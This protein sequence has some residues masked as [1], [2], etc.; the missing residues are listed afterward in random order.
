VK[1]NALPLR[2][3]KAFILD[4]RPVDI[5]RYFPSIL[6][7]SDETVIHHYQIEDFGMPIR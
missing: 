3:D 7:D 4:F 5:I 6:A 1:L 2:T